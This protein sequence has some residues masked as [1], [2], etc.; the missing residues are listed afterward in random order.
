V[1]IQKG[2]ILFGANNIFTVSAGG[3]EYL[4]RIKGKVLKQKETVYNPL[5]PGDQ[6]EFSTDV[7]SDTEGRI[8]DR[9]PRRNALMRW[10]RKR[11]NL[12]TVAANIDLLVVVASGKNPP[13]RPRFIDRVLIAAHDIPSLVLLNKVDLG[14]STEVEER[15]ENYR[16]IG[17]PV[18]YSSIKTGEGIDQLKEYSAQKV[19]VYFGQSG[20]GKSSLINAIY[21]GLKLDVGEVSLKYDRGRHTTKNARLYQHHHGAVI[22]TPGIRHLEIK[23]EENDGLDRYFPEFLSY[24]NQCSFQPCRHIH[25]PD[26]AVKA[27][28][29]RGE[30][31]PDRYESYLR[32]Y[33]ELEE[34][35]KTY[36]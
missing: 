35:G 11:Q 3:R 26:C 18:A 36:V 21:P 9:M 32:I 5:A 1:S 20:V 13:F 24:L 19:C 34:R 29:Q 17:Y 10:N 23:I 16:G 33:S 6:V 8:L 25:E 27:A 12:Q 31:H 28:V 7:H 22:D 4:C 30:I 14:V 15:L 2:T